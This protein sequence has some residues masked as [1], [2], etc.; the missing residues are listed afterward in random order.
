MFGSRAV[1]VSAI[2]Y[3]VVFQQLARSP[4]FVARFK[5]EVSCFFKIFCNMMVL[6]GDL[7]KI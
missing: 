5:N 4:T 6:Y 1:V 2:S 3:D 7:V